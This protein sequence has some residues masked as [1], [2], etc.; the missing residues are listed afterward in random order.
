MRVLSLRLKEIE[1]RGFR[2]FTSPKKIDLDFDVIVLTGGV[3]SGKSSL[4]SAIEYALFGTTFEV[5]ERKSIR[6]DDLVNDFEKEIDIKLK[7]VD[8]SGNTYEIERSKPRSKRG[9]LKI[10][11][12][13]EEYYGKNCEELLLKILNGMTYEDFIRYVFVR[14]EILEALIY[15]PP[16]RRSE[17]LDRLFGISALEEAFRGIPIGDVE[18]K[19]DELN[20]KKSTLENIIKQY[21]T[22]DEIE[23]RIARRLEEI[24]KIKKRREEIERE[25]KKLEERYKQLREIE[26]K[27]KTLTIEL[28]KNEAIVDNLRKEIDKMKTT[29]GEVTKEEI[30]LTASEL[31]ERISDLLVEFLRGKEAEEIKGFE[32]KDEQMLG[33]FIEKIQKAIEILEDIRSEYEYELSALNERIISSREVVSRLKNKLS[34]LLLEIDELKRKK[35]EY[36]ELLLKYGTPKT[37]SK[38]LDKLKEE[39]KKSET[40]G[41]EEKALL[42]VLKRT[43]KELTLKG[44]IECPI[45]ERKMRKEDYNAKLNARVEKLSRK[46]IESDKR[47]PQLRSEIEKLSEA[48]NKIRALEGELVDYQFKQ[49]ELEILQD[50]VKKEEEKYYSLLETVEEA[51]ER[52]ERLTRALRAIRRNVELIKGYY[53]LKKKERELRTYERRVKEIRKAFS[54]LEYSPEK[55]HNIVQRLGELKVAL[56][57]CDREITQ[58]ENSV[59]ELKNVKGKVEEAYR[60]FKEINR[61]IKA[62][63]RLR[64]R[65][66]TIKNLFRSIQRDVRKKILEK[67][68]PIVN[69]VFKKIYPYED[70]E[71]LDIKVETKRTSE[72][73]ER[74]VYTIYAK[75]SI[76]GEW[77]PVLNRMSD[78]QKVL[79]ALALIIAFSNLRPRGVSILI[80][81]EPI[82]NID[83]NCRK[84]IVK[85]L[86]SAPG[87]K[88]LIIA[89]Q[90]PEY[91]DIVKV[92]VKKYGIRGRIYRLHYKGREGTVVEVAL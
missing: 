71:K 28:A 26:E 82:P 61:K 22:P 1:I 16:M 57:Q 30:L 31:K 40:I 15:G 56:S 92:G 66:I 70:Y 48:L 86:S 69:D 18:E 76:D 9:R 38:K 79:V 5:K 83:A 53:E 19:I 13:G 75:R 7:L 89:T 2:S 54:K 24:E 49:R 58:L 12:N 88:Q 29:I 52:V 8:D 55:V 6:L 87:I 90:N 3:G 77:V 45:C 43:I 84:A 78:G 59:N 36:D 65:L 39:L 73:Y 72:G 10:I 60:E 64:D 68:V 50:E 81:D 80:M 4:L 34:A 42:E 62:L 37:I 41:A 63:E 32:V 14:Q 17:A 85:T 35:E 21:G 11:T 20:L 44:E 23:E 33:E 25:V 67:L 74:S 91:E 46:M 51:K 47:T 27:H